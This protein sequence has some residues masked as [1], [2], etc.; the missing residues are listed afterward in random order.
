MEM[1]RISLVCLVIMAVGLLKAQT[2]QIHKFAI[3]A[4]DTVTQGEAFN[5]DYILQAT[6]YSGYES[7]DFK[8]CRVLDRY[9]PKGTVVV[10]NRKYYKLECNYRLVT[11]KTGMLKLPPQ[12]FV[13][14][15]KKVYSAT[16][17]IFV[18]P[19]PQYGKEMELAVQ[20]LYDK[21]CMPDSCNLLLKQQTAEY[22]LFA[23]DEGR[24]FVVIAKASY[25]PYI[26]N[27]I[28]AWGRESSVQDLNDITFQ[29]LLSNY[30]KQL[31]HLAKTSTKYST[32]SL[33]SYKPAHSVVPP[34]LDK[35][36]WGQGKPYNIFC[37]QVSDDDP[38]K[39]AVVGCVP[40]AMAQIMGYYKYPLRGK[41]AYAYMQ[42]DVLYTMNFHLQTFDWSKMKDTYQETEKDT[43]ALTPIARLMATASV[44]VAAMFGEKNTSANLFNVKTALVNF[45]GYSPSCCHVKDVSDDTMLGLLYRELDAHR[46][47]ILSGESHAFVCDGYD[48][49]FL[50]FNMGWKGYSNGYYRVMLLPDVREKQLM[51]G[52]IVIGIEPGK[53]LLSKV[54]QVDAPGKLSTLLTDEERSSVNRLVVHGKLNADDI[55][56]LRRM[57]GAVDDKDYFKWRGTLQMLDLSQVKLVESKSFYLSLDAKAGGFIA[58]SSNIFTSRTYDFKRM[59]ESTWKSFCKERLDKGKG[60]LFT[61]V[62]GNYY[63]NYKIEK[64][65]IGEHM[66][67]D[68]DNL[69]IISL[70]ENTKYVRR[71]AF[72]GCSS[73][74]KL[75]LPESVKGIGDY[76]FGYTRLLSKVTCKTFPAV[77][78]DL[79]KNGCP[80]GDGLICE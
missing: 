47:V 19:N 67:K 55:S 24:Q 53:K 64:D 51:F 54:V 13:V 31:R 36:A 58:Y 62:D 34:L 65:V 49:E 72:L 12:S 46:P 2:K 4:P 48:G 44:S 7:P 41:R 26:E 18:K 37:P 56:F 68:C 43:T 1:K 69:Q 57:A 28:L 39:K 73:L 23:D 6:N 45:F 8:G 38:E 10:N 21:G 42:D 5:V 80:F 35:I 59:D 75:S 9:F 32:C 30:G 17:T 70:P 40:V 33:S 11:S 74:N 50:H 78:R 76:A 25:F 66:F 15:K 77:G 79:F 22:I 14:G 52:N 60:F 63:I 71:G 29:G 16:K 61:A 20:F 27:P 3:E